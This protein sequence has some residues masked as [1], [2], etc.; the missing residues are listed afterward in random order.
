MM[1][2]IRPATPDDARE[3]IDMNREFNDVDDLNE[4]QVREE[5][6]Q[7]REQVFVADAGERLAGYCCVQHYKSFCYRQ[8]IAELTELYVRAE[9]RHKGLASR[10]IA[11]QVDALRPLGVSELEVITAADNATGHAVYRANGFKDEAWACL[12]RKL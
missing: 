3:L 12:S 6:A 8:G 2:R 10:L 4:A 1:I 7:G 11:A 9:F 5:L